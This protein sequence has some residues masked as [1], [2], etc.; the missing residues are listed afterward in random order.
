MIPQTEIILRL[1]VSFL[2]GSIIGFERE[3][4][5]KP[6]GLRTHVL[7]SLGSTVFTI[8]SFT[9]FPTLPG[10][11]PSRVAAMIVAGIGF[12]GGGTILKTEDKVR[13]ITTAASLWIASSIGMAVG[14]GHYLTAIV[15]TILAFLALALKQLE[16]IAI[17]S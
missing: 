5:V 1:V 3:V 14:V 10:L 12:I 11:D 13:G 17:H 7:V 16:K 2:L 4:A 9:A 6:A 15:A 8:L